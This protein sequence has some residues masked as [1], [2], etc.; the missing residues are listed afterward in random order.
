VQGYGTAD[1]TESITTLH[2]AIGAGITFL[3][4][5][6][7]YGTGHNER[8]LG[9]ALAGRREEVTLAKR[10][11]RNRLPNGRPLTRWRLG[12]APSYA[13]ARVT[14]LPVIAGAYRGK[15]LVRTELVAA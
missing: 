11:T 1:D 9:H 8:L 6:M 13:V 4:T 12:N 10:R 14:R 3:D 15:H 7:S 2:R 5:A